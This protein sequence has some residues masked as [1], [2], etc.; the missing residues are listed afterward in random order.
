MRVKTMARQTKAAGSKIWKMMGQCATRF[1]TYG[2]SSAYFLF[3]LV[4]FCTEN[5][6]SQQDT[7]SDRR[8]RRRGC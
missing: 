3:M 2:S 8:S 1:F 6:S 5:F 4:L 7:N